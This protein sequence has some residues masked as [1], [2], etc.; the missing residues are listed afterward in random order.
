MTTY[1]LDIAYDGADFAGW[2]VQPGARTVQGEL[3][4]AIGRV[5]G[6]PTR[7]AVAGRTD[8]GV[9]ALGQVASFSTERDVPGS[10]Q[11]ALNSL[12]GR[13]LAVLGLA[14]APDGFDARHDAI[15]RRY[16]YRIETSTVPSP[17]EF[18]RSLHWP[19]ALDLGALERCAEAIAGTRD[20]T[21]FTKTDTRHRH[22]HRT[23]IEAAWALESES[24]LAFEVEAD[25]FLRGMVRALIGTMLEVGAGRRD[26]DGF[27]RLLDGGRRSEAGDS[28]NPAGLYLV[29]VTY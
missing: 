8:A 5:L 7:L 13:D 4:N 24:I 23:V 20:F 2:A 9:H 11:R 3:E 14:V 18:R 6:E 12:T 28:M 10:L 26:V 15:S 27:E 1:R 22:F 17:F 21:A 19:H 16:R 29:R 25:A